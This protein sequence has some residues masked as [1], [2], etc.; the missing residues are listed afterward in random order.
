[1]H[2]RLWRGGGACSP[3]T[4]LALATWTR[5]CTH[6]RRTPTHAPTPTFHTHSHMLPHAFTHHPTFALPH[7]AH[8]L[9][10][11]PSP[12]GITHTH[13]HTHTR[14][15]NTNMYTTQTRHNTPRQFALHQSQSVQMRVWVCLWSELEQKEG[16]IYGRQ[17]RSPR[18]TSLPPNPAA[19]TSFPHRSTFSRTL[20]EFLWASWTIQDIFYHSS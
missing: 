20:R 15:T 10:P 1:M 4:P 3:Y 17:A 7:H 14:H 8:S 11:S 19:N 18:L 5:T 16:V 12:I 6:A 13:T 2:N 9:S